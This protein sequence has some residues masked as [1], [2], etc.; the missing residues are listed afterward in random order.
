MPIDNDGSAILPTFAFISE[1]S[2]GFYRSANS[3]IDQ[4]YG[5]L[6]VSSLKVNH[7]LTVSGNV[8]L[9]TVNAAAAVQVDKSVT[10]ASGTAHGI[11]L[12]PTLVAA[13][14]SDI[15]TA[16][17]VQPTVTP[18]AFTSLQGRLIWVR[19]P[20]GN[21][22]NLYGI[23]VDTISAGGGVN[24]AFYTN[25]GRVRM[26][27]AIEAQDGTA[28]TPQYAFESNRSLGLYSSGA[29]T[30]AQSL[31]TLNL[32]TNSV[33]LSMRTIAASA[34]TAS[35]ANTNVARN[36]VVF[37]IG[38]ASGASLIISSGG[39]AYIFNSAASAILA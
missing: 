1:R 18:G 2:L 36:E 20:T 11:L 34:V 3:G 4:S 7:G 8:G 38:G 6:S 24:Y 32:A 17:R 23:Y 14:N 19:N 33:R 35:A 9:P 31:G 22:N 16:L 12:N 13:A 27:D 37:T 21:P 39:T 26:G 29:Q 25:T 28:I 15:F 30:I 5:T 10:A